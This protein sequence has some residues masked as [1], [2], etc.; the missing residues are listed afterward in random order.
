MTQLHDDGE[1]L[2]YDDFC[3]YH[4]GAEFDDGEHM[5]ATVCTCKPMRTEYDTI[6]TRL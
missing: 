4:D 3:P 6:V 5:G 2:E 1:Q